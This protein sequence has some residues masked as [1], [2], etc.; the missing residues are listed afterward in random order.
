MTML[1]VTAKVPLKSLSVNRL[2]HSLL[3]TVTVP[4][5]VVAFCLKQITAISCLN[6][7]FS[8]CTV[9]HVTCFLKLNGLVLSRSPSAV[10]LYSI[11]FHLH[12][13]YLISILPN[14]ASVSPSG[15]AA[16][17]CATIISNL[18]RGARFLSSPPASVSSMYH[19]TTS[20][21]T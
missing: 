21:A 7:P 20:F 2:L 11:F 13:T 4:V 9:S 14:T 17:A 3:S 16:A 12:Y 1:S 8:S 6:Q 15:E 10:T 5:K 18:S 19:V